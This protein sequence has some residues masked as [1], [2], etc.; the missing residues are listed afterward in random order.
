MSRKTRHCRIIIEG[1]GGAE[2]EEVAIDGVMKEQEE[3]NQE[4]P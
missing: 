1:E 3:K 4:E 2:P